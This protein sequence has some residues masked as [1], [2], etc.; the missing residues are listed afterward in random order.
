MKWLPLWALLLGV[1]VSSYSQISSPGL[2]TANTANWFAFALRQGLDS[3]GLRQSVTYMGI[4]SMSD[5]D[6][7]NPFSKDAIYVINQEFYNKLGK[8]WQY[9][10]ALSYRFQKE[11]E[12]TAPYYETSEGAKQEIRLYGR[13]SYTIHFNKLKWVNTLRGD[14]RTFYT[15]HFGQWNEP[16][17]LRT[18]L[19]SQLMVPFSKQ[20]RIVASAEALFATSQQLVPEKKWSAFSYTESRLCLYYSAYLFD[21]PLVVDIGYMNNLLGYEKVI[22]VHYLMMDLIWENPFG[23]PKHKKRKPVEYLE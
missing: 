22:D 7:Y 4:G 17:E 6:H 14:V 15:L 19:R 5:P 2:G 1:A 21:L 16:F 18:R 3:A 9:S 12:K 8:N 11:Y 13:L 20:R 10:V 23:D